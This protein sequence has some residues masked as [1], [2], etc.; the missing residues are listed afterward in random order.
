[1][2]QIDPHQ[3]GD[4]F[5]IAR[6]GTTMPNDAGLMNVIPSKARPGEG[7]G[8]ITL[9]NANGHNL[10]FAVENQRDIPRSSIDMGVTGK[11]ETG[12]GYYFSFFPFFDLTMFMLRICWTI[13]MGDQIYSMMSDEFYVLESTTRSFIDICEAS[14]L[15]P[16]R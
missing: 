10:A 14:E 11:V 13:R 6:D 3:G 12:T 5:D 7:E 15:I 16:I 2:A 9:T 8:P 1:M 4:L